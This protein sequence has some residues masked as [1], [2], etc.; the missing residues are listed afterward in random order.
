MVPTVW[1]KSFQ[2][3]EYSELNIDMGSLEESILHTGSCAFCARWSGLLLESLAAAFY[4]S[5]LRPSLRLD[6]FT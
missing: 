5:G 3:A 1:T 6:F 4:S 2:T